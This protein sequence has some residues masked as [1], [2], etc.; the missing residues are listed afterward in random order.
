FAHLRH[1]CIASIRILRLRARG[2]HGNRKRRKPDCDS[3]P[4]SSV[5]SHSPSYLGFLQPANLQ[6]CELQ[7]LYGSLYS[8]SYECFP[9]GSI[10]IF[11]LPEIPASSPVPESGTTLIDKF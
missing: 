5:S 10:I 1:L 3:R 9:S 8:N 4:I 6:T 2:T 11:N 7:T